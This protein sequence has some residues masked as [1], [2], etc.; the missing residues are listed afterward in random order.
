MPI[1]PFDPIRNIIPPYW[2]GS[3]PAKNPVVLTPHRCTM[4]EVCNMLADSPRRVEIL[5][6]LL[7]LRHQLRSI[8][9]TGFQWLGG[10]F[11]ERIEVQERRDPED[12]DVVTFAMTPPEREKSRA[13]FL[14]HP[15]IGRTHC[16]TA[17]RVD[18]LLVPLA[19]DPV[20]VVELTRY[21][22]G[23]FSHRRDDL[24]KGMLHVDLSPTANDDETARKLTAEPT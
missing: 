3:K 17:H 19:E 6:G 16:R 8:G 9:V 13:L 15:E 24:W 22:C 12:V 14:A 11:V 18:H 2:V 7:D 1:P 5:R 10:S 21:W 20:L 4:V 23:L